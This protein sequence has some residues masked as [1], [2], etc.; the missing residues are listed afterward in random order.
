MCR[1][2]RGRIVTLGVELSRSWRR[3]VTLLAL[4][5]SDDDFNNE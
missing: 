3:I 1:W 5:L 4:A 2:T